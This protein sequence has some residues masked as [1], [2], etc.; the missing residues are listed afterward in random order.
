[1]NTKKYFIIVIL[2]LSCF[3]MF[4]C[5]K[6]SKEPTID[7]AAFNEIIGEYQAINADDNIPAWWHL[8]IR[9]DEDANAPYV[10]FYD[11][12][13]G[14]PGVAGPIMDLTADSITIEID[15]DYYEQ[16]PDNWDTDGETLTFSYKKTADGIECTNNESVARFEGEK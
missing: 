14:N 3:A 16:V 2:V 8:S 7:D 11:N 10:S 13:A 6:E 9:N 12:E 4:G 1:M 15:P 5:Q